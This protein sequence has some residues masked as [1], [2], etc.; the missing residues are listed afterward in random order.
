[1]RNKLLVIGAIV[2]W[3]FLAGLLY[4]YGA[5]E[6]MKVA[7][8]SLTASYNAQDVNMP[9]I[10]QVFETRDVS[11]DATHETK[12]DTTKPEPSG[13]KIFEKGEMVTCIYSAVKSWSD[14]NEFI[15]NMPMK[16]LVVNASD[17]W[18]DLEP[19][20]QH[21]QV[22]CTKDLETK[23]SDTP[24]LG[25]VKGHKLNYRQRWFTSNDCY[26]FVANN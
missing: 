26:H 22:D 2:P 10:E 15:E 17:V 13:P 11:P 14:G 16:C 18:N 5:I 23:W 19:N 21:V 8:K 3:S 1:M 20:Y 4:S 24:G 6:P 25:L 9:P 12:G 7:P